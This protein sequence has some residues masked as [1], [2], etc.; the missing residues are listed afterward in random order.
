MN[1]VMSRPATLGDHGFEIVERGVLSAVGGGPFLQDRE[2]CVVADLRAEG[3]QCQRSSVVDPGE[4]AAGTHVDQRGPPEGRL[5]HAFAHQL[6]PGGVEVFA[7]DLGVPQ[8][9]PV[10]REAFVEADVRPAFDG[11]VVAEPLVR[12]LVHEGVQIVGPR[13]H[14]RPGGGFQR[15]TDGL[16]DEDPAGRLERV[17]TEVVGQHVD[18]LFGAHRD[19][20]IARHAGRDGGHDRLAVGERVLAPG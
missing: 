2:E 9:R 13:A 4:L 14:H 5:I 3:V 19:V 6:F 16:A 15:E 12:Q 18:D 1:G 20:L 17:R 11:H 8:P 10:G 7:V